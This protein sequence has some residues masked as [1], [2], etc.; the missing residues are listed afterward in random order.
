MGEKI[1]EATKGNTAFWVCLGVSIALIIGGAVV[2]PPFVIDQ[3]IFI[4]C[5]ALF[6]FAALWT[7]IKALDKGVDASI[8][9]NN[10]QID[11]KNDDEGG[12]VD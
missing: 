6:G 4:A 7:V 8:K 9:H 1:K 3:S 2:P 10:T 12:K 5:G 11:I